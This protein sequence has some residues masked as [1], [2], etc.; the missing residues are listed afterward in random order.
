MTISKKTQKKDKL[1]YEILKLLQSAIENKPTT[2][3]DSTT[4]ETTKSETTT[5]KDESRTY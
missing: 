5:S 4:T 1:T 2:N 3:D